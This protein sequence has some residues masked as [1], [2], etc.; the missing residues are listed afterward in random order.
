MVLQMSAMDN[1]SDTRNDWV[2]TMIPSYSLI[3]YLQSL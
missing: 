2:N 3:A 1:D